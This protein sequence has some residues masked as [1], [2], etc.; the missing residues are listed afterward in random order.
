MA[1]SK[2]PKADLITVPCSQTKSVAPGTGTFNITPNIPDGYK[3]IGIA[4]FY[5]SFAECSVNQCYWDGGQVT[6]Q[7]RNTYSSPLN[8]AVTAYLLCYKG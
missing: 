8:V 7:V 1:T 3:A 6:L 5:V 4:G 2:L